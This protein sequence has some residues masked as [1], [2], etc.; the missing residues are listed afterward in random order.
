[1]CLKVS[2]TSPLTHRLCILRCELDWAMGFVYYC[3]N[4]R[5]GGGRWQRQTSQFGCWH[6][7]L[8]LKVSFALVIAQI[9]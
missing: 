4:I 8:S 5:A 9:M 1:M 7:M 6:C 2:L 3:H